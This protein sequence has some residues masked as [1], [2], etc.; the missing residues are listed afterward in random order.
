MSEEAPEEEVSEE[1][2]RSALTRPEVIFLFIAIL[3]DLFGIL[4]LSLDIFF[5]LGE[6]ISLI[7]KVIGIIFIGGWMLFRSRGAETPERADQGFTRFL[8]KFFRGKYKRFLTPI[9][10]ECA[11][12]LGN[13]LPF[14]SLAVYYELTS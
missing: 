13:A 11:P 1:G 8:R 12:I 3:L 6:I 4:C 10:G 7:P 2:K 9:I 14:W 5:G